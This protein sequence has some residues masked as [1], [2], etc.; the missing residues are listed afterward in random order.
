MFTQLGYLK[1]IKRFGERAIAD[2]LKEL[3]QLEYGHM[4]GK[5]FV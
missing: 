1:G 2:I 5:T 4:P 3:K